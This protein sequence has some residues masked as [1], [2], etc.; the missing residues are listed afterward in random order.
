M[1]QNSKIKHKFQLEMKVQK[2]EDWSKKQVLFSRV[3]FFS[4]TMRYLPYCSKSQF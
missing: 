4:Q 2:Y 3:I 1:E